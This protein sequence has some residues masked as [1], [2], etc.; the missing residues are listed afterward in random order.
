MVV[1]S[2]RDG[3]LVLLDVDATGDMVQIFPNEFSQAKG[4]PA[5]LRAGEPKH[6]PEDR[7]DKSFRLRVSPPAGLGTL[8]AVVIR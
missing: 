2:P 4:V 1:T 6:V 7:P 3:R 5:Q 8:V